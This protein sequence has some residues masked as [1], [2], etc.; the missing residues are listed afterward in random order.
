VT[1]KQFIELADNS[2]KLDGVRL[3][4][5]F[6]GLSYDILANSPVD[7]FDLLVLPELNF[8]KEEID[9]FSLQRAQRIEIGQYSFEKITDPAREKLGQKLFLQQLINNA[10]QNNSPHYN[11]IAPTIACYYAPYLHPEKK[12]DE[13]QVKE[14]EKQVLNMPVVQ[15]Y[16]E[17]NFFLRGYIKWLPKKATS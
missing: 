6:T 1:L 17:A 9:F 4:S 15:A 7:S 14:F 12:W 2:S 13:A 16:P 11:L 3:L 5:I 10:M 8:L